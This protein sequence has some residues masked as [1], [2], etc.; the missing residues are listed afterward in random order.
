MDAWPVSGSII[1]TAVA[2]VLFA[3]AV[4]ACLAALLL[5]DTSPHVLQRL[6]RVGAV[7]V[8][9]LIIADTIHLLLEALLMSG[10]VPGAIWSA[11]VPVLT[12]SHF[13]AA[14]SVGLAA[15]TCWALLSM[16]WR[17]S[18]R[19]VWSCLTLPAA[20]IFAFSKVAS[21]HAADAGDFSLPEWIH[22]IHLCSTAAWAGLVISGALFVLP[23]LRAAQTKHGP[24]Q[25]ARRV[26]LA[27]TVA[28]SA[29]V[30]TGL[31]NANRGLGG[32]LVPLAHSD[33][34]IVL[35]AKLGLVGVAVALVGSTGWSICHH[36]VRLHPILLPL[37]PSARS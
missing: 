15:L 18:A 19:R 35:D 11:V 30:I 13:G 17:W 23:G 1:A 9:A 28:F 3:C 36:S 14:W 29:V 10:S 31:Y 33:W 26:S 16:A 4:G 12:Q 7:C 2:N 25:F 21:S 5:D 20:A 24:A 6:Q 22:W 8:V 34:G 27:A 37:P 32:S